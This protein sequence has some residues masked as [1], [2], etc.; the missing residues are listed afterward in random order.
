MHQTDK[1]FCRSWVF[2]IN[3]IFRL[4]VRLHRLNRKR[5]FR[6]S[7]FS[8]KT[9]KN[10]WKMVDGWKPIWATFE[11]FYAV[12]WFALLEIGHEATGSI[13]IERFFPELLFHARTCKARRMDNQSKTW[14]RRKGTK[15]CSLHCGHCVGQKVM[16]AGSSNWWQ[17]LS[18]IKTEEL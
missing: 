10:R 3:F 1:R 18:Q 15:H 5:G 7:L 17:H 4:N 6:K 8:F 16:H 12:Q 11:T 9:A 13:S 14:K 2:I